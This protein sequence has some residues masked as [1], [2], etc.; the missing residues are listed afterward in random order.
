ME[1]NSKVSAL[2]EKFAPQM[3]RT[4]RLEKILVTIC[5]LIVLWGLFAL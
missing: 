1:N 2:L 3:T 5:G 4:T